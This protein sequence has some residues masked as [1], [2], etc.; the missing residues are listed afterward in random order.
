MKNPFLIGATIYLRPLE[1]VDAPV[2]QVWFNDPAIRRLIARFQPMNQQ[3]EEAL[4]DQVNKDEHALALA[5]VHKEL[6]QP[7]GITGLMNIDFRNRHA[8][9]GITIGNKDFWGQGIGTETTALV[10]QHAFETI[11]L[12]RLGLHVYEFNERA[13]RAYERVGYRREG[14]LRQSFFSEGRYWDTVVMGLLREEWTG[15]GIRP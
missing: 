5:I 3:S 9:F 10:A 12:N 15:G 13:I 4:I 8:L 11:N 6:D 2:A 7:I 14:V 1:R